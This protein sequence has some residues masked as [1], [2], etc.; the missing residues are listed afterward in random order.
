MIYISKNKELRKP[1]P[2]PMAVAIAIT[3]ILN[4]RFHYLVLDCGVF[5]LC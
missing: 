5:R 4:T 1:L 2:Y 3:D